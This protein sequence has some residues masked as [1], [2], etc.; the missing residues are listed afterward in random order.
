MIVGLLCTM[1]LR[2]RARRRRVPG[3]MDAAA[4]AALGFRKWCSGRCTK[5]YAGREGLVGTAACG[6]P[7]LGVRAACTAGRPTPHPVG[8]EP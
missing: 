3:S 7:G 8:P 6:R 1:I 5:T 4:A 2:R